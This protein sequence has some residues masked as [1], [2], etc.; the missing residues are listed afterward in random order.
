MRGER[1]RVRGGKGMK[2]RFLKMKQKRKEN[3]REREMCVLQRR[4]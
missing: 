4:E 2:E 3:G 1:E